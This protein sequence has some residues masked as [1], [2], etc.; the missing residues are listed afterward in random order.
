MMFQELHHFWRRSKPHPRCARCAFLFP[1]PPT[2]TRTLS[3]LTLLRHGPKRSCSSQGTSPKRHLL[4]KS[5]FM[6]VLM[7]ARKALSQGTS[8]HASVLSHC[9]LRERAV[10]LSQGTS[11][12]SGEHT[13]ASVLS[14][15][16]AC[17]R[18]VALSQGKSSCERMPL[19][20]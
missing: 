10:A 1:S 18:T 15:T 2:R 4:R 8:P 14:L 3:A 16:R 17:C 13:H 12:T 20:E 5:L 9:H 6:P 7:R 11:P 19:T